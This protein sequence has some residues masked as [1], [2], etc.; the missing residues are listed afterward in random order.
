MANSDYIL[1]N[2]LGPLCPTA[3]TNGDIAQLDSTVTI[4]GFSSPFAEPIRIGS[5]AM[6][7][8]EIVSVLG[9]SGSVYTIG[10]GCCD[11]VPDAHADG[12]VIWFFDDYVNTDAIEYA[13]VETIAVK[14]LPRTPGGTQL[15]IAQSPPIDITFNARFA[16]PYPP[17]DVKVN[18][19]TWFT[20]VVMDSTLNQMVLTWGHRDRVGQQD[21][22]LSHTDAGLSSPE[23]GTTYS[24]EVFNAAGVSKALFAGISGTTATY[25]I[26]QARTDF[27][28]TTGV[29]AGYVILKSMRDGYESWQHY[30]IDFTFDATIATVPVYS[31]YSFAYSITNL[32]PLP[33]ITTLVLSG[34]FRTG[35]VLSVDLTIGSTVSTFTHTTV[36]GDTNIAGA[37]TALK[38]LIDAHASYSAASSGSVITITGPVSVPYYVQPS[39]TLAGSMTIARTQKASPYVSNNIDQVYE[40]TWTSALGYSNANAYQIRIQQTADFGGAIIADANVGPNVGVYSSAAITGA[41]TTVL[42]ANSALASLGIASSGDG[43]NPDILRIIIPAA[44]GDNFYVYRN[45]TNPGI[46]SIALQPTVLAALAGPAR[47]QISTATVP[48]PTDGY[49]YL[50]SMGGSDKVVKVAGPSD[51]AT[52]IAA[53][54][55]SLVD[56]LS[57]YTSTSSGAVATVTHITNNVPFVLSQAIVASSFVLEVGAITQQAR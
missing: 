23:L 17:S 24:I 9:I 6:L 28:V 57:N 32:S 51:T 2:S 47:P 10:R 25:T 34:E 1:R 29:H 7:N 27:G 8:G 55:A 35:Q 3:I 54:L 11:T 19:A 37:A 45:S 39:N 31:S 41:M 5:A 33:Q 26:A 42:N 46:P 36:A 43:A 30:R 14:P 13:A 38:A 48:T 22:L 40:T 12:S 50:L 20:S 53:A 4:T 21:V 16:R 56:A 15:T 44:I 52:T 49:S 18:G